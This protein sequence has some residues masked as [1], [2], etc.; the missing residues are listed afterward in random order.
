MNTQSFNNAINQDISMVRGDTLA[1]NFQIKGI[2][3]SDEPVF[4]FRV[5]KD[6]NEE[7]IIELTDDIVLEDFNEFNK[8]GTYSVRMAPI[9]TQGL[10]LGR[11]YYDLTLSVGNDVITLMRGRLE[12]LYEVKGANYD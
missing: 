11:Y 7:P 4:S 1:F 5:A 2:E 6:V 8:V 12:L 10:E 3:E 9:F